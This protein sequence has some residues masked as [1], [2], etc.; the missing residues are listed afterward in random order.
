M[1]VTDVTTTGEA[2]TDRA[3]F[4]AK[5]QGKLT[6]RSE[7]HEQRTCC[8]PAALLPGIALS[9]EAPSPTASEQRTRAHN[10]VGT[11]GLGTGSRPCCGI[12][13]ETSNHL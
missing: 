13:S 5:I 8:S 2:R 9:I 7:I 11:A 1:N 12:P 3:E 4:Y 6:W 10:T